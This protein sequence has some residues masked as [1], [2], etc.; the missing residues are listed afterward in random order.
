MNEHIHIGFT[1]GQGPDRPVN[2]KLL[3]AAVQQIELDLTKWNQSSWARVEYGAASWEEIPIYT[4]EGYEDP[5]RVL[6]TNGLNLCGTSFCLAG[7]AVLAN[8]DKILL[9]SESK[10][11]EFCLTKEGIVQRID[12]RARQVLGFDAEMDEELFDADAGCGDFEA[13][14]ALITEMTGVELP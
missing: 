3:R 14:K 9:D 4:R 7:H 1:E 12:E 10:S 8:G 5:F 6:D 2:E 13:F 11:A